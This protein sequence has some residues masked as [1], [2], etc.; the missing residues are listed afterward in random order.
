M[1]KRLFILFIASMLYGQKNGDPRESWYLQLGLGTSDITYAKQWKPIIASNFG[2]DDY[3]LSG[4]L[5]FD[6]LSAYVHAN[7][8]TLVGVTFSFSAI[9]YESAE[10][11]IQMNMSNLGLSSLYFFN[12]SF[13]GEGLFLR[14]DI[15]AS[16]TGT[17]NHKDFVRKTDYGL[18]VHFG[19]GYSFDIIGSR[20]LCYVLLS[21]QKIEGESYSSRALSIGVLL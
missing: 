1:K 8:Q 21:R 7:K 2:D 11:F 4:Q 3:R 6:A 20:I 13:F 17:I 9:R 19:G 18:G 5:H 12:Q 10:K 16:Y 15:T 14:G